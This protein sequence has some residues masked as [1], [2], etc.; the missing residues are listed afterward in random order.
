MEN[1]PETVEQKERRW[2][3]TR[4]MAWIAMIASC[5]FPGL[6]VYTN[7]QHLVDI[8]MPFYGFMAS[9]VGVYVGFSTYENKWLDN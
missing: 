5:L 6:L 4:K 1:K 2:K 3:N 8:A 9:V 7:N